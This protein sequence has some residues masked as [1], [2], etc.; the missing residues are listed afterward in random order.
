VVKESFEFVDG[1][2]RKFSCSAEQMRKS[3]PEKWWWFRVSTDEQNRYAPFRTQDNDTQASVEQRV[4]AYYD[5][6]LVKRAAPPVNRWQRSTGKPAVAGAAEA[7]AAPASA[8]VSAPV[9]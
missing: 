2:G 8:P 6:L 5:D 4:V 9:S 7:E 1:G 3:S